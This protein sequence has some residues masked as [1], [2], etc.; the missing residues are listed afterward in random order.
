VVGLGTNDDAG[1]YALGDGRAL[2]QTVDIFTPVVDSPSD[3]GRIAA[4]NALSDVYAMGATP[5]TALQYLAWPRDVLPFELA[6]RVVNAGLDVMAAAGCTVVGGHSI[7]GPEPTYGFAVTGIA[8]LDEVV[9]NAGA[10]PGD[11]I[12]LTK[13][14]GTGVVTTAIKHGKC[15]PDLAAR[16][17]EM[18]V[19]LNDRAGRALKEVGA[20]AAT[21]V[22]GYGLLG[23]LREVCLASGVGATI[24][25]DDVPILEGVTEL[26]Q[27]G[28]WA[29][30]SQRNLVSIEPDL[31]TEHEIGRVKPLID[32]Q[33]SGGLIVFLPAAGVTALVEAVPG[34]VPIGVTTSDNTLIVT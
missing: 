22:T 19:T 5:V 1:V 13:P 26:L 2:I 18:M 14:L 3:W 32:A 23:H 25:L 6:S 24:R 9:T 31:V 17:I 28:M 34:A 29:G 16:A 8:E 7:D 12:V 20:T 4:A 27:A 33:T 21:D 10:Q 11:V 30:G 15:P